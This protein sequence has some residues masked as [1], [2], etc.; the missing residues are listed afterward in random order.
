MQLDCHDS[1]QN[2]PKNTNNK[3]IKNEY[4]IIKRESLR[5]VRCSI[6]KFCKKDMEEMKKNKR[7]VI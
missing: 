5:K 7:V 4:N 1:T 3:V 2:L 6:C